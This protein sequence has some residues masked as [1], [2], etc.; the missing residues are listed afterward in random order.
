MK[1]IL[2][3][4]YTQTG[5]QKEILDQLLSP[6]LLDPS[7]EVDVHL[8][9]PV[10]DFTFPWDSDR[11]F[12]AFPESFL[13][14]PAPL[15]PLPQEIQEKDYDLIVLGYQVWYLS[16]S[17]PFNSFLQ[18]EDG[19]KLLRGKPVVTVIGCRNM[20]VMAHEKVKKSLHQLGAQ[21]VG[22]IV[23]VDRHVNHISLVTIVHWMFTGR[24][25]R[26]LGFFPKPGVSDQ[27]IK[28]SSQFGEILLDH[29]HKGDYKGM[30]D[31]L[32]QKG[33]VMIRPLLVFIDQRGSAIFAKWAA[34][35]RK[36][37][38]PGDSKRRPW[39]KAFYVYLWIALWIIAPVVS[40]AFMILHLPFLPLIQKKI[41]YYKSVP[42]Q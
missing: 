11:F 42:V 34:I 23:L 8:L 17:I 7:V 41:R 24:K 36:K 3:L 16:P 26:Y 1:Q 12:D 20:W 13:Q 18:S 29:L 2:V 25:D 22:N 19:K 10:S 4:Y 38:L 39:L 5:Q 6:L 27:D 33:A 21:L 37:G 28:Q 30:Q 14:I 32:L 9:Q 31:Q 35:V 40:A 15:H